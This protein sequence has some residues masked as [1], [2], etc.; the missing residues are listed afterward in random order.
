MTFQSPHKG[1]S[2][3]SVLRAIPFPDRKL[4]ARWRHA[5]LELEAA[6]LRLRLLE[7]ANFDPDQPRDERGRWVAQ[8]KPNPEPP[9]KLARVGRTL[10]RVGRGTFR[11]ALAIARST[12]PGRAIGTAIFAAEQL[13]YVR[14]YFDAPKSLAELQQLAATPA[15]GYDIHHIVEQTAGRRIGM[16]Q[17]E[18]DDPSNLVRIP[19]FK[20]W[21]LNSWYERGASFLNGQS[22]RNYLVGKSIDEQT[23][24]GLIGLKDIGVLAP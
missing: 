1:E 22:P 14:S 2:S 10:A 3:F 20:H 19:T 5:A 8:N 7:K 13:P 12:P 6:I 18:I 9:G 11:A 15:Q 17:A 23:R 24:I 16:T 4:I 21:E